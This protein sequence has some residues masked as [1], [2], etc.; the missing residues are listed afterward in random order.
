[1][2][3]TGRAALPYSVDDMM[4]LS[5]LLLALAPLAPAQAEDGFVSLF[6]GTDLEGWVNVNCAP[7]TWTVVEQGVLHCSGKPTGELRTSRTFNNFVL[8]LEWRHLVPGGNAGVFVWADDVTAKGVPF[9]RGI[10]VQVLDHAYGKA[11]WFTTHGDV[12]PIHGARM[13]P[14][15]GR[16]GSRAFPTEER[17]KPSPEWNHYRITCQDGEISLAVNG[18]VVTRGT[19]CSP[20]RG[21]ICL[22]SE[23]GQVDYRNIRIKEL[24]DTPVAPGD[25]ALRARGY[26]TLYTGVDLEG[27]E[28]EGDWRV[29]DWRLA[30]VGKGAGTITSTRSFG[31]H[32][33][34]LD[35]RRR[36]E[37]PPRPLRL[38][39]RGHEAGA[40]E[41]DPD[42]TW[43]E[44]WHRL[45]G[46][47]R[48]RLLTLRLNGEEIV[49]RRK[50]EGLPAEGPL[51]IEAGGPIDLAG[52]YTR[53]LTGIQ[54]PAVL[55]LPRVHPD[56]VIGFA[57]YT[58]HERTLKLT[59][60]L[61]PLGEGQERECRLERWQDGAWVEVGRAPVVEPGWTASF[62]VE[63]WDDS[64]AWSYRVRHGARASYQGEVRANPR[65]DEELVL[66][67]FTGNSIHPG[68]G[69]DI[70]KGDLVANIQAVDADLLFFSGDQVYDHNRHLAAWL[71]FGRDFGEVIRNRPTITIP[72]DHD[73]GQANLW[74][75]NGKKSSSGAGPDGGYFKSVAYVQEVER[76]QTSHLPD[77]FDPTPIDRGIGVYYTD[78]LWG[79]VSFAILEDRKF[80]T[81]PQ[82]L[83]PKQG[84]RPDHILNPDYDPASVDVP[85]A[86]LLG[87]RQHVFL[88]HWARDWDGAVMKVA[89]SQT[90]FCGGAHIHGRVGGRLHADLDSN[91]WPQT[92]RNKAIAALRRAHAFHVAG[93][94]H[95]ATVFHHG[96]DTFGDAI[97]SFCVPSIANLYLR[98]WLPLEPGAGRS[99]GQPELLGQHLDGFGNHVTAWAVANPTPERATGDA[100]T[101]RAAGF[102]VV[103]LDKAARTA[104][105]E[106]W[107]RNVDVSDPA[108]APYPGWPRTVSVHQNDGRLAAG[109]IEVTT[110]GRSDCVVQV[111]DE[112]TGELL[113]AVRA[114]GARHLARTL[115]VSSTYRVQVDDLVFEGVEYDGKVQAEFSGR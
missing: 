104:T 24:P 51:R 33:F 86:R 30:Y 83:I 32:G 11:N 37:A 77:P 9:H 109:W 79:G 25:D 34:Q 41:L 21:Y 13:T 76:A 95:L 75:H 52:I 66:C 40:I 23:G 80:K 50:L 115:S 68:H 17:S 96:V 67:A 63:G 101:T 29:R 59:A 60:Q 19:D 93:D 92:G 107:P 108:A 65:G 72:D 81:G 22:E 6:N 47:L 110:V 7:S 54:S 103:R 82:G 15:N 42:G 5:P 27:W 55:E 89:L 57:L 114:Q 58:V 61:Y 113:H 8:E 53:P 16:G 70:D 56:E 111:T 85:E 112:G 69:G 78:L 39:L 44:G 87:E 45:E 31:H 20:R 105:F 1:M 62:R 97:W 35:V 46:E 88:D 74:G 38:L 90:I 36:G 71:K 91:G 84:P 28:A 64:H 98:W 2:G 106:C 26:E 99:P 18:A 73:V 49:R 12:F 100:L 10:E 14:V 4:R 3:A 94:Q 48:G 102:G 43:G